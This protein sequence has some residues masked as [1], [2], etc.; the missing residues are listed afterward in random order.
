MESLKQN[1]DDVASELLPE[2]KRKLEAIEASTSIVL[3]EINMEEQL[4]RE[5][6]KTKEQHE[7][8][9]YS[10]QAH[11]HHPMA[12]DHGKMISHEESKNQEKPVKVC[13]GVM[14]MFICYGNK[15]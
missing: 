3:D 14:L 13:L 15:N 7:Q 5:L 4:Q 11:H 1:A 8:P 12:V 9:H 6:L 2:L 10:E